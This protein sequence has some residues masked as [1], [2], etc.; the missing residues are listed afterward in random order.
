MFKFNKLQTTR[1]ILFLLIQTLMNSQ[2]LL[3]YNI[4]LKSLSK[5]F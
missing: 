5:Q 4:M 1:I 3:N 2:L